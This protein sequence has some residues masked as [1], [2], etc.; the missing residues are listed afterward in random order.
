MIKKTIIG[1][2]LTTVRWKTTKQVSGITIFLHSQNLSASLPKDQDSDKNLIVSD[3][4]E[5]LHK[6]NQH[7]K[8][9]KKSDQLYMVAM[10]TDPFELSKARSKGD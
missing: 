1:N 4:V 9:K 7:V 3:F 5:S 6:S 10:E 8:Q 2:P